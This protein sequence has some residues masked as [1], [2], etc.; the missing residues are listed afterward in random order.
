MRKR[1][2]PIYSVLVIAIVLLAA[3]APSC[4]GARTF[5]LTMAVNPPGSGTA[6]DLTGGSPYAQGTVVNITAT[7]LGSYQ[8]VKWTAPAG[9]F[10][11]LNAA[12]TTFT[13]PAQNITA[14]ANF[15]GPL[16]HFKCY[17]VADAS[18]VD[19]SVTLTD[20]FVSINATVGQ[21]VWF[22]NPAQKVHMPPANQIVNP[23]HH[24][25]FYNIT[26]AGEPQTW[27]VEVSN[28]FGNY[29]LTVSGPHMLAVPTQK[30]EP[31][32]HRPP[33][34]LD[35][36]LV[37]QVINGPLVDT[38]V[39]L[40]DQFGN[41]TSVVVGETFLFANPVQKTVPGAAPTPILHPDEHLVFYNI[42]D[43]QVSIPQVKVVNQFTPPTA[44]QTLNLGSPAGL[45]GVPSQKVDF[46]EQIDHFKCYTFIPEPPQIVTEV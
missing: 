35:H 41:E 38:G 25:T 34:S 14:T 37:Y 3:L 7:P 43:T 36:F 46:G 21:A 6:T 18:R 28:Q 30:V 16:D 17:S 40:N 15:R 12:T 32:N 39:G 44:A 26:Y 10:A 27:Y 4:G 29:T 31:G 1:L 24:F 13:M 23:D 45:L 5:A 11:N 33:L 22:A 19:K 42:Y 20:Q 8:F 2:L 9:A